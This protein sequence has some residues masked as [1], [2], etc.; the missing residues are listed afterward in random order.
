[1]FSIA[2]KGPTQEA[3]SGRDMWSALP[4]ELRRRVIV[5]WLHDRDV[6]ACLL[7][8]RSF[9]A[10]TACD[11]ERRCY[12][13]A[14]V[15][16]MCAAG[17]LR[18]LQHALAGRPATKPIDWAMCMHAAAIRAHVHVIAWIVDRVGPTPG[19]DDDWHDV[20]ALATGS[21]PL[22]RPL[23]TMRCVSAKLLQQND[24]WRTVIAFGHAS[25]MWVHSTPEA[26]SAALASCQREPWLGMANQLMHRVS[27]SIV[28]YSCAS[29]HTDAVVRANRDERQCRAQGNL[30]EA[31]RHAKKLAE[32]DTAPIRALVA[33]G[34]LDDAVDVVSNP[35]T[36]REYH[37][38]VASA[39]RSVVAEACAL[40]GRQTLVE[41]VCHLIDINTHK[42]HHHADRERTALVRGAARGGH[43]ALLKYLLLRW[44]R[45]RSDAL[46]AVAHAV[47]NG[48][49]DCVRWLCKHNFP[50]SASVVWCPVRVAHVSALTLAMTTR[51]D[52]MVGLLASAPDARNAARLAFDDAV[53]AGDLR[54][55]RRI[56]ALSA[57]AVTARPAIANGLAP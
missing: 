41:T 6:G 56:R 38:S 47:K 26:R 11:L 8:G 5:R 16:G 4:V 18:G 24:P 9:H 22:L 57:C 48:H 54:T 49:V 29:D 35:T 23:A 39:A 13:H 30:R 1:M 15:E 36:L 28:D 51:R 50:T 32:A 17:D 10:L 27:V 44:P 25:N 55:A 33:E 2:G 45:V 31:E 34:R 46:D 52:D 37:P 40:A 20:Y 53:A 7:A 19:L 21:D 14:T 42:E 12:A 43:R 3:C